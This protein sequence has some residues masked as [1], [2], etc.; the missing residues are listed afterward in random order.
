MIFK[1][2]WR[3]IWR[4]RIRSIIVLSSIAI[5]IW[6]GL[7][8][9]GFSFGMNNERT[10]AAIG[11]TLGHSQAH[12]SDFIEDPSPSA[13]IAPEAYKNLVAALE[14]QS[15]VTGYAPR[16]M[17]QGMVASAKQTRA[18]RII[19][20][21]AE[22]ERANTTIATYILEGDFFETRVR[23]G[24]VISEKL[25]EK[26]GLGMKKKMVLTFQDHNGVIHKA[27]FRVSGI[28]RTLNA[29]WDELNIY[30]QQKDVERIIGTSLIHEVLISYDKSEDTEE[31]TAAISA[32]VALPTVITSWKQNS[33]ELGFA[34]DMMGIMLVLVLGI[35]ML[36][37]LF[38]IINNMLMA[39][40]E[41]RRELGML[42]AVGMN[43]RKLFF[44]ILIET[45]MLGLVAGP[46]GIVLGDLSV[47]AMMEVGLD[48]STKKDGLAELGMQSTIYPEI[49]PEYY[50]IIA[51]MV[52]MTALIAALFPAYKALKLNPVRAIRGN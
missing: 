5:G 14:E 45:L 26:M 25:A 3:N 20:V 9:I 39:V 43:K 31:K 10:A 44:M 6:A 30:V 38:G 16:T 23:K 36:A 27:S 51:V 2:A 1:V 34:D 46:I 19:G 40:L 13:I 22:S 7:L 28:Y 49:V 42:M 37:L 35:I 4:S 8:I 48:L 41:R 52:I 11:A 33:P 21:N 32:N 17:L 29:A 12:S 18:S 47:R 24:V 15:F 50:V